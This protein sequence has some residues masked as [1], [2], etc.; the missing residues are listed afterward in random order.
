[1]HPEERKKPKATVSCDTFAH[2]G[3]ANPNKQLQNMMPQQGL[4]LGAVND[5]VQARWSA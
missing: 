4:A 3:R 1:M 2:V 5:P